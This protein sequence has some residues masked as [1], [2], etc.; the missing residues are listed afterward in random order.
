MKSNSIENA[1][2]PW[3]SRRVARPR[4][5][6]RNAI[7]QLWLRGGAEASAI[8][9]TICVHMCRVAYV[10]FHSSY[11]NA[12]QDSLVVFGTSSA[13]YPNS[14]S[15][16]EPS[17]QGPPIRR[18]GT[19]VDI[20]NIV[21]LL[22]PG[23]FHDRSVT[24]RRRRDGQLLGAIPEGGDLMLSWEQLEKLER[25]DSA[26]ERVLSLYLNLEPRQTPRSDRIELKNLPAAAGRTP[27]LAPAI[28]VTMS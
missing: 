5:V 22:S 20:A 6:T 10:S 8:L 7:A 3:N 1:R 25:F 15:S 11:G 27:G 16:A 26:G 4:G 19:I 24:N 18:E 13:A 17:R 14:S 28:A 12:G 9:P 2:S 21:G 23:P